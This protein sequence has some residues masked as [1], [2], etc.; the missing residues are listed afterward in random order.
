MYSLTP[1]R[2]DLQLLSNVNESISNKIILSS[3]LPNEI[4]ELAKN[5][6]AFDIFSRFF[7]I[8]DTFACLL[9]T[10]WKHYSFNI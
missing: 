10:N 4:I 8:F 6:H 9:F 1:K 3:N 5:S 2:E 7:Y